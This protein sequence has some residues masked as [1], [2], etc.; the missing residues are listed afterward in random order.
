[1]SV[2]TF[3][4][5]SCGAPA[6]FSPEAQALQ[7]AHCGESTPIEPIEGDFAAREY[8]F[9]SALRSLETK[10][11]RELAANA[12]E[13]EC[14][15]CGAHFVLSETASRCAYCDSPKVVD[16]R[17]SRE[18][19]VPESLLPFSVSREQAGSAFKGWLESLWFAPNDLVRRARGEEIDGV[20][21]PY[22][23]YDTAT[24]TDYRGQRGEHYYVT[25]SYTDSDGKRRTRSVQKTRWYPAS[26]HVSLAFDDVLVC[27]SS[28]LPRLL[29]RSLEPWDLHALQAFRPEFLSGFLAERYQVE[30][31]HGFE[32]A[33]Q[34]MDPSIRERV[35]RDI[36]GDEQRIVWMRV[37]HEDITFKHLL[38]PIWISS[39]RYEERVYRFFVNARTGEVSGERP[40]SWIKIALA[41]AIGLA[42]LACGIA[43]AY[44]R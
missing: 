43:L 28:S 21:I 2:Q 5:G 9:E 14:E 40:F 11:A 17:E 1:M 13:V 36:G 7:C 31:P 6:S 23:T 12:H 29:I 15:N 26:G 33:K 16:T 30:L 19:L 22:F 32:I 42:L 27:A 39:F 34:R 8:D 41:T 44:G 25:E 37:A 18:I 35:R 3:E 10:P 4:C 24:H 38:L 20:Y